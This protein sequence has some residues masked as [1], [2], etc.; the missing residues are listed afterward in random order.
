[1]G[2][3]PGTRVPS[4]KSKVGVPV[5]RCFLPNSTFASRAVVSQLAV[6]GVEPFT[7][8]SFQTLAL[9]LAHQ[10]FLDLVLESSPKMG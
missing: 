5:M 3:A 2:T 6:D 7:I 8:Q 10:M 4:A 1:M 9:S